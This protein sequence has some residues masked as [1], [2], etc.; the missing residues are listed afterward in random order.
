MKLDEVK[1]GDVYYVPVRVTQTDYNPRNEH[2]VRCEY[3]YGPDDSWDDYAAGAL[4]TGRA[5]TS[6]YKAEVFEMVKSTFQC[7]EFRDYIKKHDDNEVHDLEWFLG[8]YDNWLDS[9][10]IDVGDEVKIKDNDLICVVTQVKEVSDG[11]ER[12]ACMVK[13]G[14]RMYISME[15][16]QIE[17]TG[18]HYDLPWLEGGEKNE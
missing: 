3:I 17:K 5:V 18:N 6:L 13:S 9:K 4:M 10:I 7:D 8:Q 12:Y 1:V 14:G 11:T 16:A 2:P 15:F